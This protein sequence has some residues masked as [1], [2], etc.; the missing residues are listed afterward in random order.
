MVE[1][2]IQHWGGDVMAGE[3]FWT[4]LLVIEG[5]KRGAEVLLKCQIAGGN[6]G[7]CDKHQKIIFRKEQFEKQQYWSNGTMLNG[8]RCRK[9]KP[10]TKRLV[11]EGTGKCAYKFFTG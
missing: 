5:W 11:P 3:G 10:G 7:R 1:Y 8:N 4:D 6:K 9:G 2:G